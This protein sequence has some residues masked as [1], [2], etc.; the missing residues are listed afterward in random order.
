MDLST[1]RL[2]NVVVRLW[3]IGSFLLTRETLACCAST[4]FSQTSSS[5]L[6]PPRDLLILLEMSSS[7]LSPP[8]RLT[9]PVGYNNVISAALPFYLPTSVV[10]AVLRPPPLPPCRL[11]NSD[12]LVAVVAL[13]SASDA[14]VIEIVGEVL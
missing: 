8:L 4:F 3:I 7:W 6:S 12:P 2:K 9:S 13:V 14:S 5:S 11:R 1:S 10:S